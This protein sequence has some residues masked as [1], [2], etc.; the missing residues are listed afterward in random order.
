MILVRAKP[1]DAVALKKFESAIFT[2]DCDIFSVPRLRYLIRSKSCGVFLLKDGEEI[3]G[4]VVGLLRRLKKPSG[5][6]YK[7]GVSSSERT[8]GFGSKLL[9]FIE[10]F[11][12]ENGMAASCAE[13]RDGNTASRRMFE[14]NGYIL[15][16]QLPAYYDDGENGVK[17]WKPL[18]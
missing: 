12:K 16:S 18:A 1:G 7:I 3:V 2:H 9:V 17:F 4:A 10:Q 14:K 13:V 11:F 6:V 8:R 15:T 5:R